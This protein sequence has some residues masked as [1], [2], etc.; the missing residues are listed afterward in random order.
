MLSNK[1]NHM[2]KE[3][4]HKVLGVHISA[5]EH[6]I[7]KEAAEMS[8]QS[9]SGWARRILIAHSERRVLGKTPSLDKEIEA[10][11]LGLE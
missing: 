8:G 1:V 7:I 4:N 2:V 6:Q 10:T 11:R 3:I 5:Q 9:M